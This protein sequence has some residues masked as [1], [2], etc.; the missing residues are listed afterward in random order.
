MIQATDLEMESMPDYLTLPFS[1]YFYE[2]QQQK[3]PAVRR[4][5]YV[6]EALRFFKKK[7]T[8]EK[9]LGSKVYPPTLTEAQSIQIEYATEFFCTS[10]LIF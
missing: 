1:A 4:K 8:M 3:A 7:S 5:M 6:T 10:N 2:S 9:F